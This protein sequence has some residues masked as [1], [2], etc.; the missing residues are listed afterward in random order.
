M[1]TKDNANKWIELA[2]AINGDGLQY[3]VNSCGSIAWKDVD[4]LNPN[5]P[6]DRY[7]VKPKPKLVYLVWA[8]DYVGFIGQGHDGEGK[9]EEWARNNTWSYIQVVEYGGGTNMVVVNDQQ[10]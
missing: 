2:Q 8:G 7:R 6:V 9:A 1:I 4:F 10:P 3:G 5:L